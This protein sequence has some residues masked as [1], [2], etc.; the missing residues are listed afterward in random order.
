MA[1]LLLRLEGPMQSWGTSSRFSVRDAGSEPS[2]SGAVGLLCAALGKPR[3]ET[4]TDA[5]R[6]PALAALARLRMGVRLDRPGHVERDFQ[7]AGGAHLRGD[8]YGVAK[9]NRM[10]PTPVTSQRYYLADAAFLVGMEGEDRDLLA[11]L[12]AALARP[13]W[14]L[15]LGRKSY[16]PSAAAYLPDGL[17]D[18]PL[19]EALESYPPLTRRPS[20]H[21]LVRVVLEVTDARPDGED[22]LD[23]PI[24][25]DRRMFAARR[26][27]SHLVQWAGAAEEGFVDAG[28]VS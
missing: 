17:I 26:V 7:T 28:S 1:T 9:A 25:F 6:W 15:Y 21:E 5:G 22:R 4:A 23:V 2:K 10:A 8:R 16:V 3:H 14:P 27:V 11:S 13:T 18:A 24:S 20:T 12:H 19:C